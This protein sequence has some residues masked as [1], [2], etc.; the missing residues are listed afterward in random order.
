MSAA[1]RQAQGGRRLSGA[2]HDLAARAA[3]I[4]HLGGFR[5]AHPH[6]SGSGI[7]QPAS[8]DLIACQQIMD[9]PGVVAEQTEQQVLDIDVIPVPVRRF[10]FGMAEHDAQIVR[11][12]GWVYGHG[13]SLPSSPSSPV[14]LCRP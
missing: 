9:R 10:V 5:A 8:V 6:R 4:A 2:I 1:H 14:Q 7:A 11:C 13:Y 12:L 3:E